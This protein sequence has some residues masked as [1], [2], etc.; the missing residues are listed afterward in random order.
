LRSP[1]YQYNVRVGPHVAPPFALVPKLMNDWLADLNQRIAALHVVYNAELAAMW[2]LP[3]GAVVTVEDDEFADMLGVVFQR[4]E[5]IHPFVDGNGRTG[6]L[7]ANYVATACQRALLVFRASERPAF[8]PAHRSAMAMRV[9]M[10]DKIRE[11]FDD[12]ECGVLERS[13][14]G[15]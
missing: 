8:Y 5:A 7:I 3:G 12:P 10:A 13:S 11:V 14:I 1:A 4:F 9:F 15:Q 6:R 2:K